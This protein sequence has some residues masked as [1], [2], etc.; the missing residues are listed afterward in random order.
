VGFCRVVFKAAEEVEVEDDESAKDAVVVPLREEVC[1]S[2][3]GDDK[4]DG[5]ENK[6]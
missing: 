4:S 6:P 5:L 2:V 1:D 3:E